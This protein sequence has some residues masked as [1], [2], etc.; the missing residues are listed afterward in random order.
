MQFRKPMVFLAAFC[1][2]VFLTQTRAQQNPSNNTNSQTPPGKIPGTSQT[3]VTVP[4]P[5]RP[6]NAEAPTGG[7]KNADPTPGEKKADQGPFRISVNEV[8]VPVTVTDEKGRFVSDLDKRDFHIFEEN[9]PQTIRFFTRERNQPVVIGFLLDL[10]AD[11]RIHWQNF[12]NAT[13]ELIQNLLTGDQKY[14]GYLITY[15]QDAEVAVDT[16]NAP[17][18]LTPFIWRAQGAN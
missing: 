2:S 10:S 4:A 9:K 5:D 16:T 12:Q 13:E 1:L 7:N 6:K 14:S 15:A 8:I 11:S 17:E 3:T 18:P